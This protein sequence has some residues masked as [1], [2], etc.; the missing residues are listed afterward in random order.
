MAVAPKPLMPYLCGPAA[1]RRLF[2]SGP[3][4]GIITTSPFRWILPPQDFSEPWEAL[5]HG[6][7]H[8]YSFPA[9]VAGISN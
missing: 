1:G 3:Y 7:S 6:L 9:G 5:V 8:G 4:S 2:A